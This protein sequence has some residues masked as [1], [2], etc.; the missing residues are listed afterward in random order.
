MR[1]AISF[2]CLLSEAELYLQFQLYKW[3]DGC[4]QKL[5]PQPIANGFETIEKRRFETPGR[6]DAGPSDASGLMTAA[7]FA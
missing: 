2:P 6:T 7:T 3:Q 5:R 1:S 4:L